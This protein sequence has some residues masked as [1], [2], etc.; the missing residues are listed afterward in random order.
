MLSACASLP[1]HLDGCLGVLWGIPN[2]GT[3]RP[4]SLVISPGLVY[5]SLVAGRELGGSLEDLS[6]G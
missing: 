4:Y 6:E 2:L 5:R 3:R 1:N